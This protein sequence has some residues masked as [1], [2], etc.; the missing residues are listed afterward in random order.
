MHNYV[1]EGV[2][3][4]GR[5]FRRVSLGRG[6]AATVDK[7]PMRLGVGSINKPM[8]TETACRWRCRASPSAYVL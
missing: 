2:Y 8:L 6:G 1:V 3:A 4:Y 5:G 7:V